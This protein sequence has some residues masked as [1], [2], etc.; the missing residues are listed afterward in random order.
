MKVEDRFKIG[1][2]LFHIEWD[3]DR[4]EEDK[5]YAAGPYVISE[6]KILIDSREKSVFYSGLYQWESGDGSKHQ[7]YKSGMSGAAC[8][9]TKR[10]ADAAA[11]RIW[12]KRCEARKME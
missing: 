10:G 6:I 8:F 1:D 5:P 9:K 4:F 7:R 3:G 11:K 12:N 2:E